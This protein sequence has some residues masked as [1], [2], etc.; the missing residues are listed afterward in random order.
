MNILVLGSGGR[1]HTLAWKIMQSKQCE[2]LFVAPGNA[3]TQ[4]IATNVNLDILDFEA[5]AQF[6]LENTIEMI[7]VGPEAPLVEGVY[8]FFT[9]KESLKHIAVIGPS[10]QGANLEG[11]KVFAKEFMQRHQIPTAK[12]NEYHQ[13]NLAEGLAFIEKNKAPFVLKADGLAGG[14]GVV[15]ALSKEEAKKEL[16]EMIMHAKFG[17]SSARVIIEEFLDGIEFSVFVLSDGKNYVVLPT[18]KDY[19]R[20]GE[21]D[22]GLNTGGMGAV[23][24][25]P[26]VSKDLMQ[27]VDEK[28]IQPTVKG[29]ATENIIYKGFIYIGCILVDGVAKVIEYNCR[30]GDPETQVVIP[31]LNNDLVALFQHC[32]QGTLNE[33]VVEA[34]A[35][36]AT[37]IVVAS[38]GYPEQYKKNIAINNLPQDSAESIVFH[39]GTKQEGKQLLSN[40]GR[41]LAVT[42]FGENIKDCAAKSSKAIEQIDFKAKYYRK[43]IGYEFF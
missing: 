30:M 18:A 32:K 28:I 40:G 31:L 14:K 22:K 2:K 17:K 20:V 12:Y 37:T 19:K 3:G 16:E 39:A 42:S 34:K 13:E 15:I 41:V 24:P 4:A 6:A 1:E 38:N 25:V 8:D 9:Q 7:V 5:L 21:G 43:D 35:Q 26:F 33:A 36:T 11:S 23:S 29:L 27:Q 10:K